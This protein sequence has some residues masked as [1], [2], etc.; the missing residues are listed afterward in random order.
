VTVRVIDAATAKEMP[1]ANGAG[2]TRELVRRETAQRHLLCRLSIAEVTAPSDFSK[3]PGIDRHLILIEG[4]GFELKIADRVV[5]ITPLVPVRFSGDDAVAAVRV[6]GPSRDF[7]VMIDRRVACA[8][9]T[10][11]HS[12]FA[13]DAPSLCYYYIVAGSFCTP[14]AA[15]SVLEAGMLVERLSGSGATVQMNGSGVLILVC[16]VIHDAN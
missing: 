11:H 9:V 4:R 6:A 14:I 15:P 1:W 7:N 16:V 3:L 12:G 2:M 5:P 10:V 8:H 13:H